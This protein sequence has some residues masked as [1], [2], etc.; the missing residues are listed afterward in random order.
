MLKITL[1]SNSSRIKLPSVILML[2]RSCTCGCTLAAEDSSVFGMPDGRFPL[3]F[4]SG[5]V[6]P[7]F[8]P[9][10][11]VPLLPVENWLG[12][13]RVKVAKLADGS[14]LIQPYPAK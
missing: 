8:R 3:P 12:S 2:W 11:D 13:G 5:V 4:R 14:K 9:D 7:P 1:A 6:F 10:P